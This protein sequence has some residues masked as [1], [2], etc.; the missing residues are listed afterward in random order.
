LKFEAGEKFH[1]EELI[2]ISDFCITTSIQEGFGMAFLE[3]WMAGRPVI[4][5]NL[6]CVT[7]DMK[8][9]GIELPGL[10]DHLVVAGSEGPVDFGMLDQQEQEVILERLLINQEERDQLFRMNSFLTGLFQ[11]QD[12]L[13]EKNRDLISHHYSLTLYE[14]RLSHIYKKLSGGVGHP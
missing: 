13:V 12:H 5:R 8:A 11:S 6:P 7:S 9:A 1:H 4:G 10:Y 14:N 3:P 2:G